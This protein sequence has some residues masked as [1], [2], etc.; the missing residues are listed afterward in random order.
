MEKEAAWAMYF[1]GIVAFQYHPRN[2]PAERMTIKQ[3][4]EVA[5]AMLQEHKLRTKGGV[6]VGWQP[7]R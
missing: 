6:W 1:A 7:Q 4:A 2:E 5:D 3:C